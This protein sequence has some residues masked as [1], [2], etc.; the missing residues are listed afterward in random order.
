[1]KKQKEHLE[2]RKG[3]RNAVKE[4][5]EEAGRVDGNIPLH[6]QDDQDQPE[7]EEPKETETTIFDDEATVGMFGGTVSVS[8]DDNIALNANSFLENISD[9][10]DADYVNNDG[11]HKKSIK[12]EL[13]RFEKALK[14]AKANMGKKK[15]HVDNSREGV[16]NSKKFAKKTEGLNLLH[17][18]VGSKR[19]GNT[20][21]KGGSKF[22]NKNFK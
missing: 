12:P 4:A 9:N 19:S 17:K 11:T 16:K 1:M 7:T 15:K 14:I 8:V 6:D 10:D 2:V 20:S 21:K 3:K 18:A 13:T 5:G 22:K